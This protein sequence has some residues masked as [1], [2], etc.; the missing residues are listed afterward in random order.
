MQARHAGVVNA[1]PQEAVDYLCWYFGCPLGDEPDGPVLSWA[2]AR[3]G[4]S[5]ADV[6]LALLRRGEPLYRQAAER[7]VGRPIRYCPPCLRPAAPPVQGDDTTADARRITFVSKNPRMPTTGAFYRYKIFR[8]GQT[9][10]SFIRRGGTRRDVRQAI[11]N[12]W[13]RVQ[14]WGAFE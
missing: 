12:G 1:L 14:A 6:V 13:I 5:Q 9:I 7:L 2:L 3:V 11:G 8:E 4:A 10:G